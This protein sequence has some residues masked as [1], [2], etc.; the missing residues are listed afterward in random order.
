MIAAESSATSVPSVQTRRRGLARALKAS[1]VEC[2]D[3]PVKTTK[4]Q[5][6]A[7]RP[8][9]AMVDNANPGAGAFGILWEI[10]ARASAATKIDRDRTRCCRSLSTL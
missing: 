10:G 6:I 1:R 2:E 8:S 9:S 5:C 4:T 7:R 3:T